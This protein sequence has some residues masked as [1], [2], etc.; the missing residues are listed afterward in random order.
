MCRV[1]AFEAAVRMRCTGGAR[2]S[3]TCSIPAS[4]I[5]S[6]TKRLRDSIRIIMHDIIPFFPYITLYNP[7]QPLYDHYITPV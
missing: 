4:K 5:S 2:P 3:K 1:R 6:D 7:L